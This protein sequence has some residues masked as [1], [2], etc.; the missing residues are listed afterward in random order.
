MT[1]H[2]PRSFDEMVEEMAIAEYSSGPYGR[3]DLWS[4]QS[5]LHK[6]SMRKYYTDQLLLSWCRDNMDAVKRCIEGTATICELI[7]ITGLHSGV[8]VGMR[9]DRSKG[10]E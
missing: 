1:P 6:Q 2:N 5:D 3:P 10:G 7:E 9:L 4:A 8:E